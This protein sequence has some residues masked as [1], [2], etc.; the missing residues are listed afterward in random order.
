MCVS[1]FVSWF[2]L[3]VGSGSGRWSHSIVWLNDECW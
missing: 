2:E 1:M 3:S